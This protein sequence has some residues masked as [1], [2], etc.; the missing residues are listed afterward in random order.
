MKSS[1]K[2][3]PNKLPAEKAGMALGPRNYLF[4]AIGAA[5][6][7]LSYAGIYLEHAVD[8]FFSLNISPITL[9]A[10]YG[11]IMFSIFYRPR[12]KPEQKKP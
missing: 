5:V 1:A 11:W 3:S 9:I 4:I 8:G 12:Q 6:I 7:G 2:N 10:G